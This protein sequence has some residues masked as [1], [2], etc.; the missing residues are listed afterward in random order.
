MQKTVGYANRPLD[1]IWARAPYL[2]NGSV[3]SMWDLLLPEDERNGGRT[4]FHVGHAV[5]DPVNMGIRTDVS[6]LA[7]RAV[8]ELDLTLPGNSN[9]GHT[10]SYYGTEL[11]DE[12]KWDLIAYLKT[13]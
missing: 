8:P 13:L 7:G 11:S 9:Q 2:H 3:P 6:E 12:D 4:S 5:Y 1:G 10:G